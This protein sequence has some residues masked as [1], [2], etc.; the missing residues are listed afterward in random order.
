MK[1]ESDWRSLR[2]HVLNLFA[3]AADT[4][5]ASELS[6]LAQLTDSHWF[7]ARYILQRLRNFEPG[8]AVGEQGGRLV[9]RLVAAVHK[10]IAAHGGDD[11]LCCGATLVIACAPLRADEACAALATEMCSKLCNDVTRFASLSPRD[12][13]HTCLCLLCLGLFVVAIPLRSQHPRG[14]H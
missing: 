1:F 3:I 13:V 11:A 10:S 5:E 2:E 8:S 12:C 14:Q 4:D 6:T 7:K 9:S